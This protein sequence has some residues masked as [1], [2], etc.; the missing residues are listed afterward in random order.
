MLELYQAYADWNDIMELAENLI[1]HLAVELTGTTHISY[2]GKEID[3]TSPWRRA[4][5]VDLIEEHA[6]LKVSLDTPLDDLQSICDTLDIE[7]LPSWGAGKLLLE[8]YEKTVEPNLWG[9]CFVKEYP[10][11][12]SPLS[13]E[14]RQKHGYTE[15][16][17]AIIAG[18]E[19]LNGISELVDPQEQ[20]KLF[21]EQ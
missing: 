12:V 1:E 4:T 3:L 15:R 10:S 7:V 20:Q 16:F 18:R 8:I 21:E 13:R 19:I 6:G 5:L 9:P 2:D 11:E 17:E 14:H